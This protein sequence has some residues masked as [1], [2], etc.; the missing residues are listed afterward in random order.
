MP[1]KSAASDLASW[2]LGPVTA[3]VI[4][5]ALDWL[6]EHPAPW[7][8]TSAIASS[9]TCANTVISSPQSGLFGVALQL[10]AGQ[11]ALVP[12]ALVVVEDH[13]LVDVV[14][15]HGSLSRSAVS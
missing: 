15:R 14:E 4:I 2:T 9:S 7:K 1:R 12:R 10:G 13:F 5:E 3:S 6:I 11:L 8:V